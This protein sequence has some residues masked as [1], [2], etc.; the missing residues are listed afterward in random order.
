MKHLGLIEQR[1]Q[2]LDQ[3]PDSLY[4]IVISLPHGDLLERV[5][6]VLQWREALLKGDLPRHDALC[7]PEHRIKITLLKRLEAVNIASYCREQETLTD[8]VLLDICEGVVTAEE[9]F[10]IKPDGFIDKLTQQQTKRERESDFKN[11][12]D[13]PVQD[14]KQQGQGRSNQI[15]TL[16]K[17]KHSDAFTPDEHRTPT[18]NTRLVKSEPSIDLDEEGKADPLLPT[19]DEKNAW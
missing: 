17:A 10:K 19:K 9:Y 12:D 2:V 15:N 5:N 6:G 8:Q 11:Q 14:S 4:S 7:W 1:Y 3:L 18:D 13:G 16:A